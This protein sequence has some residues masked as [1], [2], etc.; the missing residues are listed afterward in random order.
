MWV[1]MRHRYAAEM[2]RHKPIYVESRIR[3]EIDELWAATQDPA[4]HQRWDV[5]FG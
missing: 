2:F 4:L 5:R 3:C 1:R